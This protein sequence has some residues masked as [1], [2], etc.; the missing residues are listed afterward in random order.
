MNTL[1]V[2]FLLL[3]GALVV[4]SN[5]TLAIVCGGILTFLSILS[6]VVKGVLEKS[7]PRASRG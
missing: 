6:F 1:L 7:P 4:F 5:V 3:G 2:F